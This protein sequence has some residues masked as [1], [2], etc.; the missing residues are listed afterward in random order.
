MDALREKA[1]W[2]YPPLAGI[3]ESPT[4]RADGTVLCEPGYDEATGLYYDPGDLRFPALA[5]EPDRPAADAA[6]GRLADPLRDFPFRSDVDRSVALAALLTAVVRPA[7]ARSPMFLF[8]AHTPG[9]GKTLLADLCSLLATGRGVPRLSPTGAVE[10][11]KRITALLMS[12]T[13]VALIDNIQGAL[14]NPSLDAALTADDWQGRELGKSTMK[15]L[16]MDILWLATG[17]NLAV[18]GDLMRR[19]LRCYLSTQLE[20]PETREGFAHP[21]LLGHVRTCRPALVVAALTVV[22]GYLHAGAPHQ[23]A[24]PLGSFEPWDRFVRSPLIW[25]G[26]ADPV[27][28]QRSLR[29]ESCDDLDD[30]GDLLAAWQVCSP[31]AAPLSEIVEVARRS[32]DDPARLRAALESLTGAAIGDSD[33]AKK[34]GNRVRSLRNRVF[35]GRRLVSPGPRTKRGRTWRVERVSADEHP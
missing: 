1:A 5:P 13:R 35:D 18:R 8:D 19:A 23:G 9:S 27:E 34:L 32:G 4:L 3:C 33:F 28:S 24:P 16:P 12:G 2:A 6:L 14:G 15:R 10:T 29:Q 31:R 25:L 26:L 11:E 7:I 22:R 30:W 17:N 21:D 20:R